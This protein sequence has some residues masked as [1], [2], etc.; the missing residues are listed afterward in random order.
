MLGGEGRTRELLARPLV[1]SIGP[2]TTAALSGHGLRAD[3]T[4]EP[5][6]LEGLLTAIEA[7][8]ASKPHA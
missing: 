1:A 2:I 5:Y 8:L 4:A 6:T 7:R 3:V